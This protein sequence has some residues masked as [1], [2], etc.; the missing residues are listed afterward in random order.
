MLIDPIL[1]SGRNKKRAGV[2]PALID[3]FIFL[4]I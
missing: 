2:K 1:K 3:S 4:Q